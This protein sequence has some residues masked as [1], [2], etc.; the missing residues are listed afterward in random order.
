MEFH[1]KYKFKSTTNEALR[2]ASINKFTFITS[3]NY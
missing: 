2:K 1:V 3:V